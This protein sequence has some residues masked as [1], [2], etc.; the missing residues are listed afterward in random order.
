MLVLAAVIWGV[1]FVAQSVGMETVEAF[2]FNSI[3][4]LIGGIVLLPLVIVRL[5]KQFRAPEKTKEIKKKELKDFLKGGLACGVL[6]CIASN[7]QQLA[8]TYDMEVGKV[9]FITALYMVFVPILGFFVGRK[10]RVTG[11]IGVILGTIGLYLLC[12]TEGFSSVGVGDFLVLGCAVFYALHILVIDRFIERVDDIGLSC[13]QYLVSGIISA[14]F[15]FAFET[16][17]MSAIIATAPTILYAG[18]MSCGVAFTFQVVGQK[19]VEPTVASLLLCLESVFSVLFGWLLLHEVLSTRE[20]IGCA[21][22][23]VAVLISQIPEK[24]KIRG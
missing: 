19:S 2:T 8:F 23:F 12:M 1:S 17:Q 5:R 4:M 13:A 9:G 16:P 6:L 18:I 11:W 10:A 22:M 3:R 14:V 15:M 21:V 7:L 20:F 24:K